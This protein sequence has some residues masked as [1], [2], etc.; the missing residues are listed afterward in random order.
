MKESVLDVLMYL[1]EYCLDVDT[2]IDASREL[3]VCDL[4]EAGF[5]A[6]EISKA[7]DWLEGLAQEPADA[8]GVDRPA[9]DPDAPASA[10]AG[11]T[12]VFSEAEQQRMDVDCRGLL[13]SLEH[14]GVLE[15]GT[16]EL[17]IDRVMALEADTIDLEQLRWVVLMV[18]FNRPGEHSGFSWMEDFVCDEVTAR[19]H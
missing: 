9:G 11:A 16:R 4:A 12:R 14:A 10:G 1:F 15:P 5:H 8:D 17:V 2:D 6:E 19:L 18:L 7:F 13:T 3:L